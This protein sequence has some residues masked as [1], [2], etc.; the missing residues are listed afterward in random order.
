MCVYK[1]DLPTQTLES[2]DDKHF[3]DDRIKKDKGPEGDGERKVASQS[4]GRGKMVPLA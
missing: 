4:Y 3:R 2:H 1:L